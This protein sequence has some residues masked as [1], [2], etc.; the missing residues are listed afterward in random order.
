MDPIVA[1]QADCDE[2]FLRVFAA[3][4]T[5]AEVMDLDR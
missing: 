2:V 3:A 5:E 1:L 4:A